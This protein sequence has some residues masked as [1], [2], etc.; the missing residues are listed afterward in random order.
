MSPRIKYIV[1]LF[2][3]VLFAAAALAALAV[4]TW[5]GL[6]PEQQSVIRAVIAGR[7][8]ALVFVSLLIVVALAMLL[9][10]LFEAYVSRLIRVAEE[11]RLM[12]NVNP[13]HR[14][15]CSGP[16]E[17]AQVAAAINALASRCELLQAD[18]GGRIAEASRNLEGERNLLAALMSELS[19][20]VVVCN[21][22]G[23][24]L[25]C[26][27]RAR[28]LF[29]DRADG[30]PRRDTPDWIGLGRS[31]FAV[32][33]REVVAH[34]LDHLTECQRNGDRF[35]VAVF[36]AATRGGQLIRARIALVAEST[37]NQSGPPAPVAGFVLVL[38]N[39]G[40]DVEMGSL[41][42]RTLKSLTEGTR[43][44]LANI[45]AAVETLVQYPQMA[46]SEHQQFLDVIHD[47]T[48]K[49]ANALEQ[50][51]A[52]YA[53]RSG[54]EWPLATML[55]R[56]LMR[57]VQRSIE[58]RLGLAL[59]VTLPDEHV[60]INT[61]SFLLVEG[62]THLA[63]R[64]HSSGR[65]REMS[66]RIARS[67]PAVNLDLCWSDGALDVEAALEHEHAPI[68]VPGHPQPLTFRDIVERHGGAAWYH[69]DAASARNCFRIMLPVAE[70]QG[71]QPRAA[72]MP[73]RPIFYDFD[74]FHQ[75]G[76][77]PEID[78]RPLSEL[79]YTVFDTE[80]TG[81]QPS[82]GDEII[83]IGAV[84]V[85]NGRL[86]TGEVFEQLVNP[87]RNIMGASARIHG[88]TQ[89]MLQDQPTIERV[90]PRFHR[91]CENTVLVAH[92]AA[93]D[94]RFL[95]VKEKATGITF[96]HPVID[97]LMLS[98]VVH[99]NQTD[100][101]LEAIA[102]RLGVS[103]IGRHTALGDAIVTGEIFLKMIPLLRQQGVTTLR[104][105]REAAQ[106]TAFASVRY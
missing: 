58:S 64:V 66:L 47:E 51:L 61:D 11:T 99:P 88:I 48:E 32:I 77:S 95:Q 81:L 41:R 63:Q 102:A 53:R 1:G 25:L 5:S 45:R 89:A 46:P 74:L 65:A 21:M 72:E 29:S 106:K 17:I 98:A 87:Q 69:G 13:Q 52:T 92:N 33:D 103:V 75:A 104:Q 30:D 85:V 24:I 2:A 73:S 38:E 28:Q 8:G 67:G 23:S 90:L 36:V 49:L 68:A 96:S 15:A 9:N 93:F 16:A 14:L 97:T 105:A 18:V 10:V 27:Q 78:Q 76:Q 3:C 70:E 56:D 20:S 40:R 44:S 22:A 80:T 43:A 91:F 101:T 60:W 84:R 37:I 86:L 34:A 82:Q 6:A 26:N 35:P 83:A 62:L 42:E 12:L 100:H 19:E 4:V 54:G 7:A 94:M 57:A 59:V 71:L 79:A 39:I 31:L 55:G 50:S